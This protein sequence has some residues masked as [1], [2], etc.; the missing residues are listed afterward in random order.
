MDPQS[1]I[2]A[3]RAARRR[4]KLWLLAGVG[5]TFLVGY[6]FRPNAGEWEAL[7]GGG[8]IKVY[9]V[10]AR[11][12]S[13][14]SIS[15]WRYAMFHWASP[16]VDGTAERLGSPALE[17]TWNEIVGTGNIQYAVAVDRDEIIIWLLLRGLDREAFSRSWLIMP[18]GRELRGWCVYASGNGDADLYFV[19]QSQ[20]PTGARTLTI[21][22]ETAE[23]DLT[24]TIQ[25]ANPLYRR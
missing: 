20:I 22:L 5:V 17:A 6:C 15:P 8:E 23:G 25:V 7:P 13:R 10:D 12:V 24:H 2:H 18:D 21:R 11:A 3:T 1:P 14:V 9:K 4:W 19:R 16:I